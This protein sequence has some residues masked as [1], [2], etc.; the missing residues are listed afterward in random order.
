MQKQWAAGL[1]S[2]SARQALPRECWQQQKRV[3]IHAAGA[4]PCCAAR[5]ETAHLQIINQTQDSNTLPCLGL[6]VGGAQ[7]HVA[8]GVH[9]AGGGTFRLVHQPSVLHACRHAW[10]S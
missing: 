3:Q 8:N 7:E 4:D 1:A 10:C 2:H 9:Q 6:A 5:P